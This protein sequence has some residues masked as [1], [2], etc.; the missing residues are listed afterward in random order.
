MRVFNPDFGNLVVMA[1]G[2]L[3]SF[4]VV[5]R[6]K[7]SC[8][9]LP[10]SASGLAMLEFDSPSLLLLFLWMVGSQN[11]VALWRTKLQH[12]INFPE[13]IIGFGGPPS[14]AEVKIR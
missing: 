12:Y 10:K 9:H 3:L 1:T 13:I 14:L 11:P 4:L 6:L 2:F 8:L 7:A 5:R